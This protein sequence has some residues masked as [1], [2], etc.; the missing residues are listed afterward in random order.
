M[1]TKVST[2]TTTTV[3]TIETATIVTTY[4]LVQGPVD[5]CFY[6]PNV[7]DFTFVPVYV[8]RD[9][10]TV[11]ADACPGIILCFHL[12]QHFCWLGLAD[13]SYVTYST[14]YYVPGCGTACLTITVGYDASWVYRQY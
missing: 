2:S 9:P 3:G 10:N 11:C 1:T 6:D 13:P 8:G 14:E 4:E 5:R 7:Y 12:D